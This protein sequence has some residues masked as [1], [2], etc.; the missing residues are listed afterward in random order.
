[1]NKKDITQ[2]N[3]LG[4]NIILRVDFNVPIKDDVIQSTNRI[5]MVL[6]T[7]KYYIK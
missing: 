2:V 6:P 3:L 5:D 1:M 4:K 7:I